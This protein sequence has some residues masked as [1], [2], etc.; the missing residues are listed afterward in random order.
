M[1]IR[2]GFVSNSSVSS[3]CIYGVAIE[4]DYDVEDFVKQLERKIEGTSL[5]IEHFSEDDTYYVGKDWSSIGDNET[6]HQF[7]VSIENEVRRTLGKADYKFGTFEEA[8][9]E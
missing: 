5:K 3:F 1:K 8:C 6:G 7:K 9:N 4:R 2:C